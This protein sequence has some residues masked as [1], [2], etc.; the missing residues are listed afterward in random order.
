MSQEIFN[1][2]LPY[3][4]VI[5]GGLQDGMAISVDGFFPCN[6]EGLRIDLQVGPK[7]L[8]GSNI[9][10]Q[11]NPR[12]NENCIVR[13]SFIGGEWKTEER[14]GG[15][16]ILR[17]GSNFNITILCQQHEF[18]IRIDGEPFTT[19]KHRLNQ[20]DAKHLIIRG[21]AEIKAV[22][23]NVSGGSAVSYH[24]S[25]ALFS[26]CNLAIPY[27]NAFTFQQGQVIMM[28][29]ATSSGA[30]RFKFNLGHGND[31]IFHLDFRFNYGDTRNT[32][33]CNTLLRGA[34]GAEERTPCPVTAG[35]SFQLM[36]QYEQ[37]HFA[38]YVNGNHVLN[39]KNRD[40]SFAIKNVEIAGDVTI[41]KMSC[42]HGFAQIS[43]SHLS[44]G[45]MT[46][47][48]MS[49]NGSHGMFMV[50]GGGSF[51]FRTHDGHD[52]DFTSRLEMERFIS[53][54]GLSMSMISDGGE[55]REY[56]WSTGGGIGGLSISGSS[57][58]SSGGM[59]ESSYS[60]SS[61]GHFESSSSSY[62]A[63]SYSSY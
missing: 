6:S 10:L 3:A 40:H 53:S 48:S 43:K 9:V 34:W 58:F 33:V 23:F 30:S 20:R 59:S 55:F 5:P 18:V 54:K 28:N 61:S 27:S 12:F 45:E 50:K 41:E 52:H 49:S 38:V 22:R 17:A 24:E 25:S 57:G 32:I 26:V 7:P 1:L 8:D 13:N 19:F 15:L 11:V 31:I 63:S 60:S 21:N 39:F 62:S 36:I 29:C 44:G 37:A 14:S 47:S 35:S 2:A 4:G 51:V 46:T 16:G 56:S 42:Q